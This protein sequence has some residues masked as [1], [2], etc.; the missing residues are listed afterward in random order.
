MC[1]MENYATRQ[2]PPMC[3]LQ[4]QGRGSA[5]QFYLAK[6]SQMFIRCNIDFLIKPKHRNATHNKYKVTAK[7]LPC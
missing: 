4:E 3:R 1:R 5:V 7:K 2:W 6:L